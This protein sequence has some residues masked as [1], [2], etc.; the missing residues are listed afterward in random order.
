MKLTLENTGRFIFVF[1]VEFLYF[2]YYY[3][4]SLIDEM[5][6]SLF[7]TIM[8][9]LFY[10]II[11]YLYIFIYNKLKPLVHYFMNTVKNKYISKKL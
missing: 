10:K 4:L 11:I 5:Y 2:R 9:I 6:V 8:G 1:V 7:G 3:D